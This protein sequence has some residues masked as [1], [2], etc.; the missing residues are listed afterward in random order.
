MIIRVWAP[1]GAVLA[2][3][4]GSLGATRQVGGPGDDFFF[5]VGS[6]QA[7]AE[8][9]T[10][11]YT[12]ESFLRNGTYF[13]NTSTYD[14][15]GGFDTLVL[16]SISDYL[17]LTDNA[18]NPVVANVD[19]FVLGAGDD[20]L[21]LADAV[22]TYQSVEVFGNTDNDLIW[23]NAGDD[24][25][26]GDGG[27]DTINGGPGN[28]DIEGGTGSDTLRGGPGADRFRWSP[29][30]L[31]ADLIIEPADS[32]IDFLSTTGSGITEADF[33]FQQ[34]GLDLLITNGAGG[35]V[36]IENQF[37]AGGHGLDFM[38]FQDGSEFNLR[39]IPAPATAPLL[40]LGLLAARRRR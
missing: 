5:L 16:S 22:L 20:V 12:G 25:V 10:N 24:L 15:A 1:I 8:T 29:T 39:S 32:A 2:L 17:T 34:L 30:A 27:D 9:I 18:A 13:I 40:A 21:N 35:T 37:L 6:E 36:F 19:R 31:G 33:T 14:G 38:R 11:P 3:C 26:R 7:L 28:D 4:S 23:L